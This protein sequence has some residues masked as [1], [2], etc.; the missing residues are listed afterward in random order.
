M[1]TP[2]TLT[3]KAPHEPAGLDAVE[4]RGA[5]L[6][7]YSRISRAVVVYFAIFATVIYFTFISEWLL[8]SERLRIENTSL[9]IVQVRNQI[10]AISSTHPDAVPVL[11]ELVI[12]R[13]H[14]LDYVRRAVSSNE[15][16]GK[17]T[18]TDAQL[19]KTYGDAVYVLIEFFSVS[20][21]QLKNWTLIDFAKL[22]RAMTD[23]KTLNSGAET[24]D[25]SAHLTQLA[26]Q[27]AELL[28]IPSG[29]RPVV[30]LN[31]A[32]SVLA[33]PSVL[34]QAL[35]N[36]DHRTA[37]HVIEAFTARKSVLSGFRGRV[38]T[39]EDLEY[40][41]K[42]V[43]DRRADLDAESRLQ[44][45]SMPYLGVTM[46]K[47]AVFIGGLL[48]TMI[49]LLYVLRQFIQLR[50]LVRYV[51]THGEGSGRRSRLLLTELGYLSHFAPFMQYNFRHF[52]RADLARGALTRKAFVRRLLWTSLGVAT[53]ADSV[54]L[55]SLIAVPFIYLILGRQ[56]HQ[57]SL[58]F[59][60][61][62]G[63]SMV[64]VTAF[65]NLLLVL[66]VATTGIIIEISIR[67]PKI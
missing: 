53:I 46:R 50:A 23:W 40:L 14:Y 8:A 19:F 4:L 22:E 15:T 36:F 1:I 63:G 39:A 62:T 66:L 25:R 26:R 60:D 47:G 6:S 5:L 17:S 57:G 35:S 13:D 3:A 9:Q 58:A 32:D 61:T 44:T 52:A 2:P 45:F 48:G 18:P 54:V 27:G 33:I 56:F 20:P 67:N 24:I 28:G 51:Q 59:L 64:E 38:E 30:E 12:Q 49:T 42:E 10:A 65:S 34:N 11:Q 29:S 21:D 16:Q 31:S 41:E 43:G 55:L 37:C 7:C